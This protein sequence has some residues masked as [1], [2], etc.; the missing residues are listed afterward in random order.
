MNLN[1]HSVSI[2]WKI[3][4][5]VN[6]MIVI[7]SLAF[8]FVPDAILSSGFELF[9]DQTW[10]NLVSTNPELVDFILLTAG[11]MFGVH[12]L[13]LSILGIGITLKSFRNGESWS[14]Y[15][16][17]AISFGMIFDTVAVYI[18]GEIPVVIIDIIMLLLI[19]IALGISVKDMLSNK[20]T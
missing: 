16:Y 9:T 4:M 3:L 2:A 14:W 11:R 10:S 15:A 8:L 12:L 13:I 17:L 6:L 20:S 7:F 18:I 5:I 1:S 19:Y